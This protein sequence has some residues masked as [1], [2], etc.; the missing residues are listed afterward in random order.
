MTLRRRPDGWRSLAGIA[1]IVGVVLFAWAIRSA[2]PHQVLDGVR[3]LGAGFVLVLA[4]GGFRSLCRASAWRLAVEPP[5]H[6]PLSLALAA[7]L[8]GDAIGNVT[9]FGFLISEPSK[10]VFTGRQVSP[11][12]TIAG[13]TVEN[14]AYSASV[15]LVLVAGTA[16]LLLSFA[17]SGP[18][19]IASLATLAATGGAALVTTWIVMRRRL[20]LSRAADWLIRWKVGGR[21]LEQRRDQIAGVEARVYGFASRQPL[22]TILIAGSEAAYHLAAVAEIWT[23]LAL[24]TGTP[25]TL[26][27]SFVLEYVNRAITIGFQFVPMWLGVDEAGTSLLTGALGLGAATGVSLALVRKARV[28]VWTALGITLLVRRG[29]S[30]KTATDQA[31]STPFMR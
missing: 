15:V 29:L 11:R 19:R 17:V 27:E 21:Y 2:G 5:D 6:L 4:L 20:V 8:A 12:A 31:A 26:L 28:A 30:V 14:L 23:V 16:A 9:P 3:R 25:P 13:L 22:R 24:I 18:L 7:F 1:A 10:V